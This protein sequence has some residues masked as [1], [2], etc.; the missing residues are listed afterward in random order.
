MPY[1][2]NIVNFIN[3]SLQ[4]TVLKDKR[5]QNSKVVG[6]TQSIVRKKGDAFEYVPS[7]IDDKGEIKYIGVDDS[8]DIMIYHKVNTISV[9]KANV[10]KGYGDN[11]AYDANV[12]R[13]SMIVFGQRNKLMLSNDDLSIYLQSSMPEAV[14]KKL[15]N[16]LQFKAANINI[17]DIVLNDQQVFQEEYQG[18]PFFLKPEQYLFKINYTIESAFLKKC[19]NTC[20]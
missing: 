7:Y 8:F 17:S 1:L 9:S 20:T 15:L 12:A 3:I 19:F 16:E 2:K 14:S 18:F 5:F 10:N 13:M 6:I 4:S 11:T